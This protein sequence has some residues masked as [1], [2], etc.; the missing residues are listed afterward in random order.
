MRRPIFLSTLCSEHSR[1]SARTEPLGRRGGPTGNKTKGMGQRVE[2][3]PLQEPVW[4]FV[5]SLTWTIRNHRKSHLWGVLCHPG[6]HRPLNCIWCGKQVHACNKERRK[7]VNAAVGASVGSVLVSGW[8]TGPCCQGGDGR[9]SVLLQ[10]ASL[11]NN[12]QQEVSKSQL[13]L[14]ARTRQIPD[15]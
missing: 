10:S 9:Q 12:R 2:P 5:V 4:A 15:A 6:F 3:V 11:C 7:S 8:P 14:L 1:Q 13:F